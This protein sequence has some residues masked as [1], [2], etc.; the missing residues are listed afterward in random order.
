MPRILLLAT[1]IASTLLIWSCE[2]D[3]EALPALAL[4]S[5]SLVFDSTTV[6]QTLLIENSGDGELEWSIAESASW[7]SVTPAQGTTNTETDTVTIIIDRTGLPAGSH[8]GQFQVTSNGGTHAVGVQVAT[9]ANPLLAVSS[10]L[11]SFDSTKVN[12]ALT[13][14]NATNSGELQWSITVDASWLSVAPTQGTT[15]METDTVLVSIDRWGLDAGSHADQLQVTSN[16][17]GQAISVQMTMVTDLVDAITVPAGNFMMGQ[18]GIAT[19]EHEVTLTRSFLLSRMEVT[20]AQY[21]A[22]LQWALELGLITATPYVVRA[23]GEILL[24]MGSDRCEISYSA[25]HFSLRQAPDAGNWGFPLPYDPALHPVQVVSWYGAACYCDWVS[26]MS[27]L[28]PYYNGDWDR[29]PS[30]D[31]PY[32]AEGWRL[33][34]EVEWEYAARFDDERTYPWGGATPTCALANVWS[35]SQCVGWTSPVGTHPDGASALGLQDMAGSV[36]EWCNDWH[37]GYNGSTQSDPAGPA[38]GSDRMLRGGSW[39]SGTIFLSSANRFSVTPGFTV[40]FYG[41]RLC[42]TLP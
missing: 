23:Y 17:G 30:P 34:T 39:L 8:E 16:G 11:L 9:A 26:Q 6:S 38:L 20:N 14:E 33:P 7:L 3:E 29:I 36:W 4:S 15:T 25:G 24:D 32:Q 28:A 19:P 42:R 31:N 13:I 5:T 35:H 21:M 18:N 27:G 22:G 1:L 2:K 12:L 40:S 10:T 41:F 37:E